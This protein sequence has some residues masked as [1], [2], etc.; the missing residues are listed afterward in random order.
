MACFR[1]EFDA[2]GEPLLLEEENGTFKTPSANGLW[3][4]LEGEAD[5]AFGEKPA[6]SGSINASVWRAERAA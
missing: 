4:S 6:S 3:T 5:V 2:D 1:L